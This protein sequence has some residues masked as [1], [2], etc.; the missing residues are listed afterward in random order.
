MARSFRPVQ[1]IWGHASDCFVTN[2]EGLLEAIATLGDCGKVEQT[3]YGD[4]AT[5]WIENGSRFLETIRDEEFS[6]TI[7]RQLNSEESEE[8]RIV[9]SNM[10]ALESEWRDSLDE[11]GSLTF[12]IDAF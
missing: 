7:L 10:Q 11:D 5:I 3:E 8:V 1:E 2:M 9:C 12:Y 4:H 6:P